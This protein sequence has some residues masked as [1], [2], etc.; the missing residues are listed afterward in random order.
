MSQAWALSYEEARQEAWFLTD[1]M[2]YEL[3]LNAEQYDRAYQVNLDYLMSINNSADCYGYYWTY[4]DRD[5]R[6][7]FFDWQYALYASLDYFYRPIRW[8]RSAWYF[9]IFDRYRHG[10]FFFDRPNVYASYRGGM[11]HRRGRHDPSPYIGFV[12]RAGG[13]LRDRYHGGNRTP[14]FRPEYGRSGRGD[15]FG[16]GDRQQRGDRPGGFA[17]PNRGGRYDNNGRSDRSNRPNQG[18]QTG[19]YNRPNDNNRNERGESPRGGNNNSRPSN[20]SGRSNN[21]NSH[22][23]GGTYSRPGGTSRATTSRPSNNRTRSTQSG[24]RSNGGRTFGR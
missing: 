11:W 23:G 19:N 21:S 2:A 3:N 6:C 7:I 18:G 5:L 9:P 16:P 15:A 22:Q 4:R 10:Y 24:S 8:L 12:S 1:K 20:N 17:A 14:D 13:G